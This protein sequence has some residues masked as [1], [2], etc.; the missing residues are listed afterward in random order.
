[1]PPSKYAR[2]SKCRI[3]KKFYIA[4]EGTKT[5]YLYF[6]KLKRA[7]RLENLEIITIPRPDNRTITDPNYIVTFA[8]NYCKK[9]NIKPSDYIHVAIVIDFDRWG[10]KIPEASK[11]ALRR[12]YGFYVSNPCIE[13][14]FILHDHPL[15]DAEKKSL[16]TC[17]NCK[18]LF[19]D[20]F[21]GNYN[22][23]YPFTS[24]AI[25]NSKQLTE[26]TESGWP[27]EIG[28]NINNLFSKIMK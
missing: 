12:K 4:P 20:L 9:N 27:K 19:N 22:K 13:L 24:I 21:S 17:K 15:T 7:L 25:N 18:Q 16:K 14:W 11:D 1:M 6:D 5:E 3:P 2:K 28:T 26:G 8:T 23:L 10:S